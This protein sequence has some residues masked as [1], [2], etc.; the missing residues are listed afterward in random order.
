MKIQLTLCAVVLAISACAKNPDK[1]SAIA[2]AG[3]P[4]ARMSCAQ[5]AAEKLKVEQELE[6]VSAEQRNAATTDT[7]GVILTGVPISSLTGGDQEAAI[8]VA[9]GRIQ[10]IERRELARSC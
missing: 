9:K 5:L 4:Y 3:E 8:G 6:S 2:V 10:A 7:I 1:I